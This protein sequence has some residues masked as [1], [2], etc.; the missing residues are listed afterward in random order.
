MTLTNLFLFILLGAFWGGS[1]VAIKY[2]VSSVEASFAA[3]LRMAIA[4][5]CIF[6]IFSAQKKLRKLP[7]ELRLKVWGIGLLSLGGPFALLFWGQGL[8]S[9][10][11]GGLLNASVPIWTSLLVLFIFPGEERAKLHPLTYVGI[12]L[13]FGGIFILF[14]PIL[15]QGEWGAIS[16][17]L[18][19]LLGALMYA[20]GNIANRQVLTR[21]RSLGMSPFLF[22][23]HIAGML[24]LLLCSFVFEPWSEINFSAFFEWDIFLGIFYL[25]FFSTA[26]ALLIYFHLLRE[27]GSVRTGAVT[28]LVPIFALFW[29]YVIFGNPPTG[30]QMIGM[31]IILLSIGFLRTRSSPVNHPEQTKAN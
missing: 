21:Y 24:F 2:V 20:G 7:K 25:G 14:W 27:I 23:Q 6:L 29:D 8:I 13:G 3:F 15:K 1:F 26:I 11:L 18:A 12:A 30:V 17:G 28:Y 19:V 16:G 5:L 22:H 9:A 10:G 31:A 4:S